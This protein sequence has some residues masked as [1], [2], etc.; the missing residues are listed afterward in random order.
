[1]E[2]CGIDCRGVLQRTRTSLDK[3]APGMKIPSCLYRLSPS[4]DWEQSAAV[5]SF[6]PFCCTSGY[7]LVSLSAEATF[8]KALL[9]PS[10][11]IQKWIFIFFILFKPFLYQIHSTAL[12]HNAGPYLNVLPI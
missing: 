7:I 2:T 12:E 9:G 1:M 11:R 6:D 3:V 8:R 10:P 5:C 4:D